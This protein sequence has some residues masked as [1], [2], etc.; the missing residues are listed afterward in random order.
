MSEKICVHVLF[1]YFKMYSFIF[2]SPL[3]YDGKK[4]DKK[5]NLNP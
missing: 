4:I 5:K 2:S 1:E 3:L